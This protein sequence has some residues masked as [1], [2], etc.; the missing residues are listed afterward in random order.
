MPDGRVPIMVG[1]NS[2]AALRRAA[3][4]G[5]LWQGLPSTPTEFGE[6]VHRLAELAAGRDVAAAAR[7][8][9]DGTAPVGRVADDVLA[10]RDAGATRVAV[11][12]GGHEGGAATDEGPR[13]GGQPLTAAGRRA[14]RTRRPPAVLAPRGRAPGRIRACEVE[15]AVTTACAKSRGA[16][17]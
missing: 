14:W 1:G 3:R 16:L 13:G 17:R 11:H 15:K 7:I 5:D 4:H 8:A 12:V 9:W 6:R 2:D 10:Y